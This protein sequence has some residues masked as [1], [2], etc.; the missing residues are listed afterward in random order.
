MFSTETNHRTNPS[1]IMS[2]S[3]VSRFSCR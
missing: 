2:N 3:T 1:Y